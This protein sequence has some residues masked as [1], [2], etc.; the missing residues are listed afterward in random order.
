M[1][2]RVGPCVLVSCAEYYALWRQ[3][4]LTDLD[5]FFLFQSASLSIGATRAQHLHT[6]RAKPPTLQARPTMSSDIQA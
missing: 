4:R 2:K 5:P 3:W 1:Y 6:D